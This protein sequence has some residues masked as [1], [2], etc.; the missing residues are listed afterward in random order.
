MSG[1]HQA[2]AGSHSSAARQRSAKTNGASIPSAS[3]WIATRIRRT[4]ARERSP[5]EESNL[6]NPGSKDGSL[7]PF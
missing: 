2:T 4:S 1:C 5:R 6:C 7:Y 3:G